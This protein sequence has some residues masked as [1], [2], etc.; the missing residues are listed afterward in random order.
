M[1]NRIAIN[2][3]PELQRTPNHIHPLS[4]LS[5]RI[6]PLVNLRTFHPPASYTTQPSASRRKSSSSTYQNPE[7]SLVPRSLA[8]FSLSSSTFQSSSA[9]L[10][11]GGADTAL[12]FVVA[13]IN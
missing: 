3:N 12:N 2:A 10:N 11:P 8:H 1:Y 4:P 9:N 6:T 7:S 13:L 5:A